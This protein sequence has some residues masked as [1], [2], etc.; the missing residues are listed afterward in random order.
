SRTANAETPYRNWIDTY[1]G[2]E[3]QEVCTNVGAMIEEATKSRLG[4]APD[5]N[6][7]WAKLCDTFTKATRL[8]V[9]FWDMAM[10]GHP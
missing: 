2:A 6:P 10:R 3:Y 8:E 1:S 9:G 5:D 7:R 4:D